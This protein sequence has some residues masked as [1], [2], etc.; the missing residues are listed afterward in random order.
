M[1]AREL[2]PFLPGWMRGSS[3]PL[4][5]RRRI[6]IDSTGTYSNVICGTGVM[7][8]TATI[9]DSVENITASYTI[10][11]ADGVGLLLIGSASDSDGHR[12]TGAGVALLSPRPTGGCTSTAATGFDI[13]GATTIDLS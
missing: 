13:F 11:F 4:Q 8:G 3:G 10:T 2:R 5:P 1:T 12:G 6:S 7:S 9:T